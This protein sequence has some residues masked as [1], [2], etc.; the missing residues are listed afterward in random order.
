MIECNS[1]EEVRE[2]INRI[3]SEL[4]AL[5]AER[6]DYVLQ[7]MKFKR[8]VGEANVP[9]R[10]EEIL[11]RVSRLAEQH[12]MPPDVAQRVYRAMI[13]AFVALQQQEWAKRAQAR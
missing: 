9:N 12:G 5:L 10:N 11:E 7:V 4:V 6:S 13:E 3:D 1:L 8:G 2:Q